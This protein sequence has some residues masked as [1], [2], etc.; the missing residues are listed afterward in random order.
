M[1]H[2]HTGRTVEW[3][4][5][6]IAFME[7]QPDTNKNFGVIIGTVYFGVGTRGPVDGTRGSPTR[8]RYQAMCDGWMQHGIRPEGLVHG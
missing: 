6:G 4:N 1:Q 7:P 2:Y 5:W 8:Q 3:G